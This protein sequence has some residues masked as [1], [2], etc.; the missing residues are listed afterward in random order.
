MHR[1]YAE[2]PE[3]MKAQWAKTKVPL[4]DLEKH[5]DYT[6]HI[7]WFLNREDFP[8]DFQM[9]DKPQARSVYAT[10]ENIKEAGPFCST[11]NL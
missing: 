7:T 6:W 1:E 8:A 11:F 9:Y 5:A 2:L 10:K 4:S 3:A